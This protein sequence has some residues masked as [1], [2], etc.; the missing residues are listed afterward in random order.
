MLNVSTYLNNIS[1]KQAGPYLDRMY[2][3][4]NKA[5]GKFQSQAFRI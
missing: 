3:G 5:Y 1:Q 4:K 2:R